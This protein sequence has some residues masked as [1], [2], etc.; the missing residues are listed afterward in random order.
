MFVSDNLIKVWEG[1]VMIHFNLFC[2]GIGILNLGALLGR[3]LVTLLPH[4]GLLFDI[5]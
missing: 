4:I 3:I 2:M 1:T 5:L